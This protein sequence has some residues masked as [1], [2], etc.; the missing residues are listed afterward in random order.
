MGGIYPVIRPRTTYLS[1]GPWW[2]RDQ[3][4]FGFPTVVVFESLGSDY[5]ALGSS[6][7][8]AK[9]AAVKDG[10]MNL[11]IPSVETHLW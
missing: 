3:V 7:G 4:V 2:N 9:D 10:M 11:A 6:Q 5:V 8:L 1:G